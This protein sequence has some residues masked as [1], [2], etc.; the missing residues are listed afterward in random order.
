MWWVLL[1][2]LL[3]ATPAWARQLPVP[4]GR[5]ARAP[6]VTVPQSPEERLA[7]ARQAYQNG[8]L[9]AAI[10]GARDLLYPMVTLRREEDV[11]AAH[12]ILALSTL[13]TGDEAS[14]ER[15]FASLLALQPDFT[16][17]PVLDPPQAVVFLDRIRARE[18]QR[19]EEIE[20]RRREQAETAAREEERRRREEEARRVEELR[21]TLKP[22]LYKN[23]YR[24][25]CFLPFG[26]GQLQNGDKGRAAAFATT[27]IALGAASLGMW[28]ATFA[29]YDFG[30]S[31][32]RED[33]PE[34]QAD[35][36]YWRKVQLATIV[37]GAVFWADVVWGIADA[38]VRY[39]PQV[40]VDGEAAPAASPPPRTT[41]S[42][43]VPPGGGAGLSIQGAF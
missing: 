39:K 17:D 21:K 38:L 33:T 31:P 8:D 32:P 15:E 22:V 24:I 27:Q 34:A 9:A 6:V 14:A 7:R 3:V 36:A 19:L 43:F 30:R 20:R 4:T 41:L 12:R 11:V 5:T 16:L 1:G 23:N 2:F 28:T 25:L 37:T 40:P 13:L 26:V 35:L 42:P 10:V 29:H 18:R